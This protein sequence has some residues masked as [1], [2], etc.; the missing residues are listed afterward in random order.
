[1]HSFDE[2][3]F[4]DDL[5]AFKVFPHGA[6]N[7]EIVN[8][9][10]QCQDSVHKWGQA[11][12][13]IFDASKESFHI[14]DRRRPAGDNFRILG[15][16]F[17]P[18]LVMDV[19]CSEIAGHAHS[20]LKSLLRSRN[21]FSIEIRIDLYKSHVLSYIEYATPAIYHAPRFFLGMVDRVQETLLEETGL[22]AEA[23]LLE[24]SLAPLPTRR[25]IAMMGLLYRI[26]K[27]NAPPQFNSLIRR[28]TGARF[29]RNLRHPEAQHNQQLHDPLDG[30][31]GPMMERSALSLIHTFNM[32]PAFVVEAVGVSA[33][34][35]HL[36]NGVKR[37]HQLGYAEWASLLQT[38]VRK[39]SLNSFHQLFQ[40][41]TRCRSG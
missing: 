2:T 13:V 35:R 19:A 24:F 1:M 17:D 16:T 6:E 4:A 40:L 20:R 10:G 39:M 3:V 8:A 28:S 14:L 21:Y 34:Q 11:N 9:L 5:N 25:D 23:A 37:A 31:V 12:Q 32:L 33:F 26:C 36:Q 15:V 22:S 38:G 41:Q 29:P 30:S 18:K 7:N 27:G